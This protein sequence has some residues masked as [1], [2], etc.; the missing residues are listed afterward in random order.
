MSSPPFLGKGAQAYLGGDK[1][2]V[3]SPQLRGGSVWR[4][5][6]AYVALTLNLNPA[7]NQW[8]TCKIS[9]V[10]PDQVGRPG[11]P[12]RTAPPGLTLLLGWLPELYI[13]PQRTGK[14][15]VVGFWVSRWL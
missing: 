4:Q 3:V 9:C 8:S 15:G 11:H 6:Q 7:P 14:R 2:L 12:S 10:P 13:P 5:G 1:L